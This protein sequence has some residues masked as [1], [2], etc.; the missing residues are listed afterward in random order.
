M[1]IVIDNNVL[2]SRIISPGSTP[3]QAVKKAFDNAVILTSV[4]CLAEF[5]AVLS[6]RK[7]D[8]YVAIKERLDFLEFIVGSSKLVAVDYTIKACRDPKD[9]MILEVAV[10]GNA[11]MIVTGDLDLLALGSFQSIPILTPAQYLAL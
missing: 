2:I 10:N 8:R 1:R 11:D 4:D 6:R 3:A 9:N 5:D 7:F